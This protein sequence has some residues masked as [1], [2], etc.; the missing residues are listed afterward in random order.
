MFEDNIFQFINTRNRL[1]TDIYIKQCGIH[2]KN[3]TTLMINRE[4]FLGQAMAYF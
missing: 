2:L 4:S 1:Q 3:R